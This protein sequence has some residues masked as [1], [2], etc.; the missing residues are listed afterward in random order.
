LDLFWA[1]FSAFYILLHHTPTPI[2]HFNLTPGTS[3][4]ANFHT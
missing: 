1:I 2:I 4:S 3:Y